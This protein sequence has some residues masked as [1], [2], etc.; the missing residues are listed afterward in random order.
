MSVGAGR[1]RGLNQCLLLREIDGEGKG[2]TI[3]STMGSQWAVKKN[4]SS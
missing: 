4:T 3:L 1:K 2:G